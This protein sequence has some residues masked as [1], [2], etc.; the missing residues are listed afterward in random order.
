M[1]EEVLK[2]AGVADGACQEDPGTKLLSFYGFGRRFRER[3]S[4]DN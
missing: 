4:Q 2:A 1:E 3:Q